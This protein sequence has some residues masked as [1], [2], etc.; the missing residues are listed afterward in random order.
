MYMLNSEVRSSTK[1]L[2][3]HKRYNKLAQLFI[4]AISKYIKRPY[5]APLIF[6]QLEADLLALRKNTSKLNGYELD[7]FIKWSARNASA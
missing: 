5:D 6:S 4:R 7:I 1:L 2:I 3:K